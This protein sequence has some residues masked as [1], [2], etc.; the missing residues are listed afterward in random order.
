MPDEIDVQLERDAILEKAN[1]AE[2]KRRADAIPVG[3]P[4]VCEYCGHPSKRLVGDA[5]APCRD[6]YKLP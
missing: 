2:Y 1:L 4:G 6:R 3:Y 5:C